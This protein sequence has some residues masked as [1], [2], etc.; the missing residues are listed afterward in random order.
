[1]CVTAALTVVEWGLSLIKIYRFETLTYYSDASY[2]ISEIY[3]GM[4]S[5]KFYGWERKYLDTAIKDYDE[6]ETANKYWYAPAVEAAKYAVNVLQGVSSNLSIYL[7]I[8]LYLKTSAAISNAELLLLVDHIGEMKHHLYLIS[9]GI[10]SLAQAV[11]NNNM[12]EAAL[13]GES[14]SVLSRS[15]K[16][17]ESGPSMALDSC[18]F[19][20]NKK[21]AVLKNITLGAGS[22]ELVAVVGKVASGKSSLLLAMC[23][24]VEMTEGSGQVHGTIGYVEQSPWIMNGTLRDN[25]TFGR[26]FDEDLYWRVVHACAL[27]SDIDV[28]PERDLTEI[29]DRGIN[30]SG[31]QKARLAL[32]RA[33]YSQADIYILDD[34]LSAVD[35]QV[36]R[37][38]L[39][40][41]IMN[42]GILGNKLRIVSTNSDHIIPFSNQVIHLKERTANVKIQKPKDY[43]EISRRL[44]SVQSPGSESSDSAASDAT[45]ADTTAD[46]QAKSKLDE[47]ASEAVQSKSAKEA[48]GVN[49]GS[50]WYLARLCDIPVIAVILLPA[51]LGPIV[52]FIGGSFQ[53]DALKANDNAADNTAVLVYLGASV[54]SGAATHVIRTTERFV[55]D[56]I[57]KKYLSERIN[58]MFLRGL[59]YA[60]MMFFDSTNKQE[61]ISAYTEGSDELVF[62]IPHFVRTESASLLST[63]LAGYRVVTKAPQLILLTPLLAYLTHKA[64]KWATPAKKGV[65]SITKRSGVSQMRI[66]DTIVDGQRSIRL[67]GVEDHFISEYIESMDKTTRLKLPRDTLGSLWTTI[68]AATRTISSA[69]VI[70][71]MIL[72]SHLTSFRLTSG[73]LKTCAHLFNELARN[74]IYVVGLRSRVVDYCN[75]AS[76][77]RTYAELE[78]EASHSTESVSPPSE[79]PTA[80]KI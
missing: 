68:Y 52:T 7:T 53:L 56:S 76:V 65:K 6:R 73:E 14:I 66:F 80:G 58:T 10:R 49:W 44:F 62:A 74:L 2:L 48:K 77:L 54:L 8:A 57:I 23:S 69:I 63:A 55:D 61:I 75:H 67:L 15:D 40:N 70:F 25:I 5:I 31:G 21:R 39:D 30:I 24:E 72:Q 42:T 37:H 29:G 22:G 26:E 64:D 9:S 4:K 60:P 46:K 35:E 19:A 18:S 47:K 20:W 59:V 17:A 32:A 41:V 11:Y 34:P 71:A 43:S 38:L 50:I 12:L 13:K 16:L 45:A 33:V 28:W 27:M 79:W 36:K 3:F 78:P 1:M 51:L